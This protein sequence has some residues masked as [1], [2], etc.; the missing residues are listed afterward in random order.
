MVRN[1][2][3]WRIPHFQTNPLSKKR[4]NKSFKGLTLHIVLNF[5]GQKMRNTSRNFDTRIQIPLD[6]T[7]Y[8]KIIQYLMFTG[9]SSQSL[10]PRFRFNGSSPHS[11]VNVPLCFTSPNYWGWISNRYLGGDDGDVKQTPNSRDINPNP[12]HFFRP[13]FPCS[14]AL[15]RLFTG[16][17]GG[18]AR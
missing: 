10:H 14:L 15:P 5:G 13:N 4:Q 18:K 8:H 6:T 11:G 12:C 7:C 2:R 1:H 17:Q 9:W 16:R 3:I